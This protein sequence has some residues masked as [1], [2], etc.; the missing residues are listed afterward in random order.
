MLPSVVS[1]D[2]AVVP[3]SNVAA[4]A[5]QHPFTEPKFLHKKSS[6]RFSHFFCT[7]CPTLGQFSKKVQT[8]PKFI[9]SYRTKKIN[10][11][12]LS[13][14]KYM[15]TEQSG[16]GFF[17]HIVNSPEKRSEKNGWFSEFCRKSR[18][19]SV[20]LPYAAKFPAAVSSPAVPRRSPHK[21]PVSGRDGESG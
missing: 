10:S 20:F 15:E 18:A 9:L 16:C 11:F 5:A 2:N 6:F 8:C 1:P 13:H 3:V 7:F 19:I 12:F 21:T 4:L 14:G 17:S